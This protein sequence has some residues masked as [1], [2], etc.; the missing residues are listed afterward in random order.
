MNAPLYY[1]GFR[2]YD[3]TAG[4]WPLRDPIREKGGLNLY[5]FLN[6][7]AIRSYDFLGLDVRIHV[8]SRKAQDSLQ[9]IGTQ[10]VV[11]VGQDGKTEV[12]G[13]SMI[14]GGGSG[15]P[16]PEY[17]DTKGPPFD[18][19]ADSWVVRN[20]NFIPGDG[21]FKLDI[22]GTEDGCDFHMNLTV[23]P[24]KVTVDSITYCKHLPGVKSDHNMH[25]RENPAVTD[26]KKLPVDSGKSKKIIEACEKH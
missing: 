23:T 2:Y 3:P 22:Y 16:I 8:Q 11:I 9:R 6:N 17:K 26:A 4:R 25:S 19:V 18:R 1:Y 10:Y 12:G 13:F 21:E 15:D 5:G 7:N 24:E 14:P 20:T